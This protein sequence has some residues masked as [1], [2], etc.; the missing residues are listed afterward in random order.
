[1]DLL[2]LNVCAS[3]LSEEADAHQA[4]TV[5]GGLEGLAIGAGLAIPTFALAYKRTNYYRTLPLPLKAFGSVQS[6]MHV[7]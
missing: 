5:R 2:T 1:M 3:T 7:M 4:A 6:V